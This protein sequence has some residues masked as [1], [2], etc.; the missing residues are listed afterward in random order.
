MK[1]NIASIG[2]FRYSIPGLGTYSE[3]MGWLDI[4]ERL[5]VPH[6]LPENDVD[7]QL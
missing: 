1:I 4:S 6:I 3:A 7:G 5:I 2:G